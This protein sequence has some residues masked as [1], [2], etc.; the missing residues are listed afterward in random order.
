MN[1]TIQPQIT[2]QIIASFLLKNIIHVQPPILGLFN[3]Q[4]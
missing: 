2:R 1:S 4:T 3:L